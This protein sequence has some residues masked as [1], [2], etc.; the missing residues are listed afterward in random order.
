MLP[1]TKEIS[2]WKLQKEE[3]LKELDSSM[4]GL[5]EAEAISRLREFGLNAIPHMGH[6]TAFNLLFSQL[7][8]PLVYVLVF[9]SILAAF[10]GDFTEAIIIIAIMAANTILGFYLEYR[11]DQAVDELRKYLSYSTIVI[12]GGKKL[13]IDASKLVPGDFIYLTIGDAVPA[14]IR[15][16]DVDDLQTDESILTGESAS[17][18]KTPHRSSLSN[19]SHTNYQT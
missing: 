16:L 11:A 17:I 4:S 15:L 10:L 3:L 13:S 1:E 6:K 18:A 7:R 14:D 5:G 12:R 9:A 2:Y 8:N 19:L